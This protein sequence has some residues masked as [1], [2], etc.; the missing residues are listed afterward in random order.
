[1]ILGSHN[2]FSYLPPQKWWMK[3]FKCQNKDL[4]QQIKSG[5]NALDL[6]VIFH[7]DDKN[8]VSI[9]Y[10]HWTS[11]EKYNWNILQYK[12]IDCIPKNKQNFFINI[13]LDIKKPNMFQEIEF[14]QFC[15]VFKEKIDI[16]YKNI[17]LT[18]GK[19]TCDDEQVWMIP[20]NNMNIVTPIA[21]VDKRTRWYEHVFPYLFTKRMNKQ[22]MEMWKDMSFSKSVKFCKDSDYTKNDTVTTNVKIERHDIDKMNELRKLDFLALESLLKNIKGI[23]EILSWYNESIPSI[24]IRVYF[25]NGLRLDIEN[26]YDGKVDYTDFDCYALIE[27]TESKNV[28]YRD[29]KKFSEIPKIVQMF[30]NSEI[31]EYIDCIALFDFI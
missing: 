27:I 3:F 7:E 17:I 16:S 28:I 2:S 29:F 31:E 22:N 8:T 18:G 24:E 15:N 5:V 13:S 20:K 23:T 21:G 10:K 9:S 19:R 11:K 26:L 6:K 25:N 4:K 14:I 30:S 1:M 12:I